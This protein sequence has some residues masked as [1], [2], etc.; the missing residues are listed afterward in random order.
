M[1]ITK[2]N[3]QA[4][5]GMAS[6]TTG[7]YYK[8]L[9]G[10]I[11]DQFEALGMAADNLKGVAKPS[12]VNTITAI[13]TKSAIAVNN[14]LLPAAYYIQECYYA[15][16]AGYPKT[17]IK[18]AKLAILLIRAVSYQI[19]PSGTLLPANATDWVNSVGNGPV[20]I[21]TGEAQ[22]NAYANA[23]SQ[24]KT[25]GTGAYARMVQIVGGASV[26]TDLE[27]FLETTPFP[28]G[29]GGD[30]KTPAAPD[31]IHIA[32]DSNVAY[33]T[34][35]LDLATS[36]AADL[37]PKPNEGGVARLTRFL[38]YAKTYAP[39]ANSVNDPL[40]KIRIYDYIQYVD[41]A[42]NN[43]KTL[44]TITSNIKTGIAQYKTNRGTYTYKKRLRFL[45]SLQDSLERAQGL[46]VDIS[47]RTARDLDIDIMNTQRGWMDLSVAS[48]VA[49][50]IISRITNLERLIDA[51]ETGE[52]NIIDDDQTKE[53]S[54]II[55]FEHKAEI[56][57]NSVDL[58]RWKFVIW[59]SILLKV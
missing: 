1:A 44:A 3:F 6:S 55:S 53:S 49:A 42:I 19:L 52:Q 12:A 50:E 54:N 45:T 9:M 32:S 59:Q 10:T 41:I 47:S 14:Y 22:Y 36:L 18:L 37:Y 29:D 25:A 17:S 2:D 21:D 23:V 33:I 5:M 16:V 7:G 56:I 43:S 13:K 34:S 11:K 4:T 20:L 30:P 48:I 26:T 35:A 28:Y 15:A 8:F 27:K 51:I 31:P 24:M 57:I 46:L 39:T 58:G 40:Y 38:E